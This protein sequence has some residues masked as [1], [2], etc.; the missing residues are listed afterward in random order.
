MVMEKSVPRA[1]IR[2][3]SDG[4][5][6][7]PKIKHKFNANTSP[8]FSD[9]NPNSSTGTATA[10]L[11][12]HNGPILYVRNPAS[13]YH[14]AS[15][16]STGTFD[17]STHSQDDD[18]EYGIRYEKTLHVHSTDS[19][20]SDTLSPLLISSFPIPRVNGM[21]VTNKIVPLRLGFRNSGSQTRE[22]NLTKMALPGIREHRI[23]RDEMGGPFIEV[24]TIAIVLGT[25]LC[26]FLRYVLFG[27][28]CTN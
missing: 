16:F 3:S 1:A 21:T 4:R 20:E 28:C 9:Y 23:W 14:D 17:P 18:T 22:Y 13:V 19:V 6:F 10:L 2:R 26:V 11:I 7:Y 24:I 27:R 25:S 5:S 15:S 8:E 12:P